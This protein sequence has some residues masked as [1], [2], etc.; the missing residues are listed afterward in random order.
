MEA[1]VDLKGS[2]LRNPLSKRPLRALET[3]V[4]GASV[5]LGSPRPLEA[6]WVKPMCY[7]LEAESQWLRS[8]TDE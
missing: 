8:S 5:R 3:S 6:G 2:N 7:S 4:P 1:V